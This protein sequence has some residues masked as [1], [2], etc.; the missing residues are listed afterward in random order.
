MN[1]DI[2]LPT[3]FWIDT[4][5]ALQECVNDLISQPCI[6]VDTESN[7]LH[8]YKERVCLIQFSTDSHDYLIDPL[9]VDDLSP[10]AD[11]FASPNIEKIF[12]AS[13]Y[14]VICLKRDFGFEFNRLFDTMIAARILGIR[15]IGLG[16]LLNTEFGIE[17]DKKFQKAD[18]ARRPLPSEYQD[19]ARMDTHYLQDLRDRMTARLLAKGLMELAQEEFQRMARV[20]PGEGTKLEDQLWHVNGAR[21]LTSRQA[22]IL[23]ELLKWREAKAK[24]LNR[25]SFKVIDTNTLLEIAFTQSCSSS[26]LLLR[27]HLSERQVERFG[28]DV[29]HAVELG[30]KRAPMR[31]P[32]NIKPDQVFRNRVERLKEF[33]KTAAA[34]MKV[35]SDII[36]PKDLLYQL[37]EKP[38]VDWNDF[39]ARMGL[40]PWRLEH[41]GEQIYKAI[42]P[43]PI[44]EDA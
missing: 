34:E 14:D 33:R 26:S 23:F 4:S 41:Y 8:A 15:E 44:V 29:I 2:D 21:E 24:E 27:A 42:Y 12:H 10:L 17:V 9:A 37:A 3:L 32:A 43:D 22:A 20:E 5:A 11:V 38:P 7:S 35:E 13:E 40:Y 6:A 25:P 28:V 16:N 18:W 36:L 31:C 30:Q 19:Y 1:S 39:E